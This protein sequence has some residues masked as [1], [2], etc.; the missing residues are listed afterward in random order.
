M[1]TPQIRKKSIIKDNPI[2]ILIS[3]VT[4]VS[5]LVGSVLSVDSRYAKATDLA[6]FQVA[7]NSALIQIQKNQDEIANQSMMENR[8]NIDMLSK[9]MIEDK[10]FDLQLIPAN[11][12]TDIDNARLD[13]YTRDLQDINNRLN[14]TSPQP[15]PN[16][17]Q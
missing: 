3:F 2:K 10:I 5:M 4:L 17:T 7:E 12:R 13:K 16:T 14:S 9:R 1:D 15:A 6:A 8:R 11:K